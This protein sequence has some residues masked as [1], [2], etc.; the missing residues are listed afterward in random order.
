[1]ITRD[2]ITKAL[3]ALYLRI[4]AAGKEAI[5]NRKENIDPVLNNLEQDQRFGLSL[6]ITIKGKIV[7]N[8][9][10]LMEEVKKTEPEQYF[11]PESDL[12]ITI[13]DLISANEGYQRD[14]YIIGRSVKIIEKAINGLPPF[15]IKFKGIIFSNAA[16]LAKGYYDFELQLIRERMRKIALENDIDFKERYQSISAHSTIVRFNKSLQNREKLA[17]IIQK[18]NNFDIGFMKVNQLDL[19]VH[20]WYNRK[21]EGVGK[22][23]LSD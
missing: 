9:K 6:L 19:V 17:A 22:F 16:I 4:N 3:E 15:E 23:I 8:F 2:E 7:E 12:H 10:F 5:L 20:D 21:K 18:Y 1:M 11:Y 14:D 13:L